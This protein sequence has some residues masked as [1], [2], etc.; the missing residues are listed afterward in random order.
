[1]TSDDQLILDCG[2]DPEALGAL[3]ERFS[4]RVYAFLVRLCGRDAADDLFQEVWL[5][6]REGSGATARAGAG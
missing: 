5:K 4:A 3:I 6:V 2:R 1:M